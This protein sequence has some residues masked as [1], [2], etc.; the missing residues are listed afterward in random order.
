MKHKFGTILLIFALV[1]GFMLNVDAKTTVKEDAADYVGDV[2]I[3]GSSRF[4]SNVVVTLVIYILS[5]V[6]LLGEIGTLKE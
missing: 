1:F 6:V 2:Y 3:I 4:D 5:F